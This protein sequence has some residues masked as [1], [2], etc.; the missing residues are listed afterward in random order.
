MLLWWWCWSVGSVG[1]TFPATPTPWLLPNRCP[2]QIYFQD[3]KSTIISERILCFS[4]SEPISFCLVTDVASGLPLDL[5]LHLFKVLL[6][7]WP[8]LWRSDPRMAMTLHDLA[9]PGSPR[10]HRLFLTL[11]LF[12]SC[13]LGFLIHGLTSPTSVTQLG[14]PCSKCLLLMK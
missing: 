10:L 14:P 3:Q 2:P 6:R 7:S 13:S 8:R 11:L 4:R 9:F 1:M 12:T 5:I